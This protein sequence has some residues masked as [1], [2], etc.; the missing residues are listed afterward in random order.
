MKIFFSLV[1]L[2]F[3]LCGCEL[4]EKTQKSNTRNESILIKDSLKVNQNLNIPNQE[5]YEL[6]DAIV[7]DNSFLLEKSLILKKTTDIDFVKTH[8]NAILNDEIPEVKTEWKDKDEICKEIS[9]DLFCFSKSFYDIVRSKLKITDLDSILYK[10]NNLN[11][12]TL[13]KKYISK[14]KVIKL[15]DYNEI[16]SSN[17]SLD[18]QW[19]QVYEKFGNSQYE[20]SLP[21]F[22]DKKDLAIVSVSK[23][24]GSLCASLGTYVYIKR[25][26][27]WQRIGLLGSE[28]VS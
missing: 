13:D 8:L 6:I 3:V 19:E 21:I 20:F 25:N 16:M 15:D 27:V 26:S 28:V 17:L 5:I 12:F 24:C 1:M 7:S 22:N 4:K 23:Y 10:Y 14:V 18:E 2:I 9:N 11:D